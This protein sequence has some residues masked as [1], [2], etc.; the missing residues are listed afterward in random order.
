MPEGEKDR[1][2][3]DPPINGEPNRSKPQVIWSEWFPREN[4]VPLVNLDIIKLKRLG[5]GEANGDKK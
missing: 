3:S 5:E 4:N 1:K 2:K